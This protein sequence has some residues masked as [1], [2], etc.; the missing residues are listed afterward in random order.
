MKSLL[1]QA[2]NLPE[3]V[4]TQSMFPDCLET[5]R[6]QTLEKHCFSNFWIR[7]PCFS[8]V[9]EE[10]IQG[11][12]MEKENMLWATRTDQYS[13]Q[14]RIRSKRKPVPS[15]SPVP[16]PSLIKSAWTGEA[17]HWTKRR[18]KAQDSCTRR[19]RPST[20][21]VAVAAWLSLACNCFLW[22]VHFFL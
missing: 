15:D 13:V 21:I 3:V 1:C 17:G 8:T 12:Y 14:D 18:C 10:K 6:R 4:C 2:T 9:K 22:A 5:I 11:E 16:S 19:Q 7:F 20:A